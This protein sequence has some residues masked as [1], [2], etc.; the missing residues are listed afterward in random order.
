VE[1][2]AVQLPFASEEFDLIFQFTVFT[3]VLDNEIRRA[4]ASEVRRTLRPGGY[5]IWYDFAYSNPKNPN[6]RGIRRREIG[7]LL[8]GFDLRF[9]K[10]TLAPPIGRRAVKISPL[11][12]RALAAVPLLRTHYFCFAHKP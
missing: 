9:Q 2:S 5:F 4:I 7:E 11:L 6:V 10:L 12:Y 1:G 8:S 3:S